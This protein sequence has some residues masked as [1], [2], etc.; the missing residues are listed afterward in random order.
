M[1]IHKFELTRSSTGVLTVPEDVMK[2]VQQAV[3]TGAFVDLRIFDSG[4]GELETRPAEDWTMVSLRSAR[5]GVDN[6]LW[7]S[8]RRGNHGPRLKVAVDPPDAFVD[9]GETVVV[10]IPD[11][12]DR[13]PVAVG[14]TLPEPLWTQVC[15][16]ISV[17]RGA[18]LAHWNGELDGTDFV[19]QMRPISL[20]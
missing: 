3:G 9:N 18:L 10:T 12:A 7:V 8:A 19:E 5:T 13:E 14:G 16:F 11:R 17:N 20:R 6:T 2:A 15:E 1:T 4:V